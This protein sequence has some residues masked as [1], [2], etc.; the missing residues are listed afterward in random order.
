MEIIFVKILH[1]FL[2]AALLVSD[3]NIVS[4]SQ[5]DVVSEDQNEQVAIAPPSL[6]NRH[7]S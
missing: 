5:D 7:L 4:V 2:V 6:W 1:L 3:A